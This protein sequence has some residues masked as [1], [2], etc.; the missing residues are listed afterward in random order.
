[1]EKKMHPHGLLLKN[2]PFSFSIIRPGDSDYGNNVWRSMTVTM[3]AV[4]AT[5]VVKCCH[6]GCGSGRIEAGSSC[7]RFIAVVVDSGSSDVVVAAFVIMTMIVRDAK[8]TIQ[9]EIDLKKI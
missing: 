4:S 1:M 6:D 5:V 7:G 9:L 3:D 8:D 2:H